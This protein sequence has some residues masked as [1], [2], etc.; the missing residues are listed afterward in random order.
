MKKKSTLFVA[1]AALAVSFG[2]SSCSDDDMGN[3]IVGP[4]VEFYAIDG[5]NHL[6]RYNAQNVNKAV[7]EHT[8]TGTESNEKILGIDFRPE[9][10][11][12]YAIGSSNRIYV[13]NTQT[14]AATAVG[15]TAF[16]PG[17]NADMVGFD[18]NPTVDR[19][20]VV[21][22]QG[23]NLRIHPDLGTVAF[24]DGELNGVADAKVTAAAYTNNTADATTTTLYVIDVTTNRLYKQ[25]PPNDGVLALVGDL[26]LDITAAGGFDIS[27]DGTHI[28]ATLEVDGKHAVY[29]INLETGRATKTTNNF[30]KPIFGMAIPTR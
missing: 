5:E 18:F 6:L 20:R 4:N 10:G 8:I 12:L 19:I 24:T 29:S 11:E 30:S 25:D 22:A 14:G 13:L 3:D 9:N 26:G 7:A 28:L 16:T 17:L 27:A 2:S 21:T 1:L 15:A 23:Q